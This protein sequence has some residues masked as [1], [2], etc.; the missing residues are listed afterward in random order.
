MGEGYHP[1]SSPVVQ[2]NVNRLTT[3]LLDCVQ[4]VYNLNF[5]DNLNVRISLYNHIVTFNIRM[6]YGIQMENPILEAELPLRLCDG[7]ACYG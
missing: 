5:R 2:E 4:R 3:I 6:K 7:P 1:Q